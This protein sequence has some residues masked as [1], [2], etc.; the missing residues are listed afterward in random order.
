MTER[1][2]DRSP[3][4]PD[5][6]PRA[7]DARAIA[8][9][10]GAE[11]EVRLDAAHGVGTRLRLGDP[12]VIDLDL[13]P[14]TRAVRLTAGDLTLSLLQREPP[15]LAPEGVVFQAPHRSLSVA[16]TGAA[17]LLFDPAPQAAE[18]LQ[19]AP[20]APERPDAP[21]PTAGPLPADSAAPQTVPGPASP[22]TRT[23]GKEDKQARVT[24]YGRLATDVRFKTHAAGRLIGEFVLAERIDEE[25]TRWHKV[26][27]FDNPRTERFVASKLKQLVDAGEL[28]RG[29][30]AS[31]VGYV[32]LTERK[33]RDGT[34]ATEEQIYAVA[35]KA[36]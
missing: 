23:E 10:L 12:P 26:A 19:T 30:S 24:V 29:K 3:P 6:D 17:T 9:I 28:A 36:R 31:V 33:K 14:A 34:K 7:W 4:P 21:E 32:H 2:P 20:V 22:A 5:H 25:Q 27:A 1:R 11:A 18:S 15:T 16:P 8:D 35:I 13:F